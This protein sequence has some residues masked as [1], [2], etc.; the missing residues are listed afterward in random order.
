VFKNNEDTVR[1][2]YDGQGFM[3]LE[4]S[5]IEAKFVFYDVFGNVLYKWS[6]AEATDQLH[7]S[8]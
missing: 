5:E 6:T 4:V 7:P 3:S 2:F 8:L 1:F